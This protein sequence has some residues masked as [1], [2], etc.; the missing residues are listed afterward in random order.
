M[1]R[2]P[3]ISET[4]ILYEILELERNGISV[5]VF[6]LLREYQQV[7]HPEAKDVV[8]RAYFHP[9]ISLSIIKTSLFFFLHRPYT[10]LKTMGSII[11]YIW[12]Y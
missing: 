12:K 4:F 5:E 8:K 11:R 1:S 2:F 9:I 6:P 3:K 7:E 10:Y